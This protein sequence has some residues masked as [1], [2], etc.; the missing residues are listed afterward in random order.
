MYDLETLRRLNE[1]AHLAAV[2]LASKSKPPS[3][4]IEE[5]G[6]DTGPPPVFPLS[7]LARKLLGGPPSLAYFMEMLEMSETFTG[8]RDLVRD[9]LPEYELNIMAEDLDRRAAR[10]GQLFSRKYFPLN[11]NAL[12][13]EFTM[14]DLLSG[15]PF[16]PLG[17]SYEGYH[18]FADFRQGYIL[19][20]SL[21]ECPWAEEDPMGLSED[22]ED[23]DG[24]PG[25]RIP[26]LEAVSSI[27]GNGLVRLIPG[28]GWPA[29][30][31]H[32]M[33]DDTEF[34][35][36]GLFAAWVNGNTG[37]VHLDTK[38]EFLE[39]GELPEWNPYTVDA[40]TDDWRQAT[41]ILDKIH[42]VALRL[43]QEPE[44]TFRKLLAL[45][46]GNKDI[47]IPKEQL[48]LPIG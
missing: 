48:P 32:Q 1:Q 37:C 8:F 24:I 9:Y 41:E 28:R 21:V 16:Q 5:R 40:M 6:K 13:G 20:L 12:S 33:T 47:V 36:L 17:F 27:V 7:V 18:A 45:L 29:A 14:G 42:R 34:D 2:A 10:F 35:G 30:E 44:R 31:L 43:E 11:D 4:Q 22:K 19:A 38:G 3:A 39:M 46:T 23:A 15:I 25:A 26:I